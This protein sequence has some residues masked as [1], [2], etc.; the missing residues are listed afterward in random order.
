MYQSV[1]NNCLNYLKHKAIKHEYEKREI[2][3]SQREIKFYDTHQTLVEKELQQKL[4]Q[5]IKAL[6][7]RYRNVFELS[8]FEE[9]SNKEIA[10]NLGLSVRTVETQIYRALKILKQKLKS[11]IVVIFS[12]ITKK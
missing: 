2:D 9:L 1:R 12:I 5:A 11:E 4:D 3:Q 6:P 7:D 10:K 8:R